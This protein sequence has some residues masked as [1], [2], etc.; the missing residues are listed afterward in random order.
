MV[1]AVTGLISIRIIFNHLGPGV[2]ANLAIVLSIINLVSVLSSSLTGAVMRFLTQNVTGGKFKEASSYFTNSFFSVGVIAMACMIIIIGGLLYNPSIW[3][4]LP[5][6]F[7]VTMIL[8]PV[9]SAFTGILASG[10]F[11][12]E[13]FVPSSL[14]FI[15]GQII[16]LGMLVGLL[17]YVANNI[18]VIAISNIVSNLFTCTILAYQFRKTLPQVTFNLSLLSTARVIEFFMFAGWMLLTYIGIYMVTSGLLVVSQHF[19]TAVILTKMALTFQI[20]SLINRSLT[21]FGILTSPATYKYLSR[22]KFRAAS[23]MVEKF[24]SLSFVFGLFACLISFLE[25]DGI[26]KLWL[27]KDY[28]RDTE[29][30]MLGGTLS[31]TLST[32]SIPLSVFFAGIDKVKYYGLVSLCEG[33]IVLT[34][35]SLLLILAPA[36]GEWVVWLP[37]IVSIMKFIFILST[38]HDTLK[39]SR[40]FRYFRFVLLLCLLTVVIVVLQMMLAYYEVHFILRILLLGAVYLLLT[41]RRIK[42]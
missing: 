26:L 11:Y 28:P 23:L 4:E 38:Q 9:L 27:G 37:A 15:A 30:M 35:A 42:L 40:P 20:G 32:L 36:K 41:F 5:P 39:I 34:G 31:F 2:Y 6:E 24:W 19:L 18:W 7:T 17:E 13:R 29:W 22:Q 25:G 12:A 21:N 10:N 3:G 16:Y 33:I 14:A 8:V 1:T